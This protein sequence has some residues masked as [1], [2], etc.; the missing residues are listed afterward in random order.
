[1]KYCIL[2]NL[3]RLFGEVDGRAKLYVD[4]VANV[5]LCEIRIH[6]FFE[7]TG[8][9]H[10]QTDDFMEINNVLKDSKV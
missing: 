4:Q 6:V 7:Q 8:E 1:M 3:I 2:V 10:K 9:V 5:W